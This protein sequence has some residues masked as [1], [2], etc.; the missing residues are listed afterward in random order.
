MMGSLPELRQTKTID[1][2]MLIGAIRKKI[3]NVWADAK[4]TRCSWISWPPLAQIDDL[5]LSHKR[6]ALRR[7][8]SNG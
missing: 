5:T 6:C 8:L 2:I 4:V 3:E 1:L 7:G